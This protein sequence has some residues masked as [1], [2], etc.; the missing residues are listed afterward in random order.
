MNND[1][2]STTSDDEPKKAG[3]KARFS[4][5]SRLK[6]YFL[7]GVLITAPVAITG[8]VAWWLIELVDGNIVPLIPKSLNPDTYI[9]E[10]LGF[11]IGLPGLG[12]VILLVVITLIGALTAGLVGRWVLKAGESILARMPVIR[13]LYAGTKQILETVLKQ[14]SDAF[15]QAVLVEYPRRGAWAVAFVSSNSEGELAEHLSPDFIN[16]YVP[17]T[18]NP[19]SGFLLFVP[20]TDLIYLNMT[21]EE[22]FKM[23]ISMGIVMPESNGNG[24][25]KEEILSKIP[26]DKLSDR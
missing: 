2:Q 11:E 5:I 7:A 15:R 22:A 14:Q 21:V 3:W 10:V 19:T 1:V 4:L 20:K 16:I 8:A 18:P 24:T 6:A 9:R 17:T 12:L 26:E 23:L 13:G 25:D